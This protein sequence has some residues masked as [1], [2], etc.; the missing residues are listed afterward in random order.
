LSP[1]RLPLL[2]DA[3]NAPFVLTEEIGVGSL[4][5]IATADDGTMRAIR[6]LAVARDDPFAEAGD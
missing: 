5:R 4:V 6:M 1:S 2:R 3:S